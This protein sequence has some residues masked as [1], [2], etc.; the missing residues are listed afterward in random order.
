MSGLTRSVRELTL[1][2]PCS[3][4]C[5]A[6]DGFLLTESAKGGYLKQSGERPLEL[7]LV[8]IFAFQQEE[9]LPVVVGVS[10]AQQLSEF[11]AGHAAWE[12]IHLPEVRQCD[13]VPILWLM[14][15]DE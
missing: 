1:I 3:F 9:S 5:L 8:G 6:L 11:Y 2:S 13:R 10:H 4:V 14:V 15:S 7:P 12:V